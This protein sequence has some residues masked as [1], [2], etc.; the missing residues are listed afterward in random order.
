MITSEMVEDYRV[1]NGRRC[2]FCNS[3]HLNVDNGNPGHTM[4]KG[5]LEGLIITKW[6]YCMKEGCLKR[7]IESFGLAERT[8]DTRDDASTPEPELE[9]ELPAA[10]IYTDGACS[11]NPG[12]GG[13]A[14]IIRIIHS[15]MGAVAYSGWVTRDTTN[16]Q[17]EVMAAIRALAE[18][19]KPHVISLHSDSEY[20]IQTM[21]GNFSRRANLDLWTQLDKAAAPHTITWI[22]V[23]AG[24]TPMQV[25][26]DA[27]AKEAV[28]KAKMRG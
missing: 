26:C 2:P 10:T 11:G 7:W 3:S 8:A 4:Q 25:Q 5:V 28:Q 22:H 27:L 17:M 6:V 14:Y 23:R 24:S 12:P 21:K 20:L 15:T 19:A 13:Y 9:P 1:N 18:L 16:Q